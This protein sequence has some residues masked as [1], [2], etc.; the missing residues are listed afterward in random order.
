MQKR[1]PSSLTAPIVID[2]GRSAVENF[3]GLNKLIDNPWTP[4]PVSPVKEGFVTL[5]EYE[6]SAFIFSSRYL[7]F[8]AKL[9]KEMKYEVLENW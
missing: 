8:T 1:D 4:A 2:S 9:K 3:W 5:T 7:H 6:F